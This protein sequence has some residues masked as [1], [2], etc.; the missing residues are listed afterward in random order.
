MSVRIRQAWASPNGHVAIVGDVRLEARRFGP[1]FGQSVESRLLLRGCGDHFFAFRREADSLSSEYAYGSDGGRDDDRGRGEVPAETCSGPT[2]IGPRSGRD[3]RCE[4]GK[5]VD[6]ASVRYGRLVDGCTPSSRGH[7][8]ASLERP[9]ASDESLRPVTR[10]GDGWATAVVLALVG[11]FLA[12]TALPG[13]HWHDTA[14]FIAIGR[15]LSIS[16]PPGHPVSALT[17]HGMQLL[18][19]GDAAFRANVGSAVAMACALAWFHRLIRALAP[20]LPSY[21]VIA[22]AVLPALM[23]SIW[24]QGVR[25][26]VY[27]LQ[28]LLSVAAVDISRR[29]VEGRDARWLPAL[30]LVFGLAGSNHSLVGAALLPLAVVA[31]VRGWLEW[32]RQTPKIRARRGRVVGWAAVFGAIGLTCYLYLPLRA[33]AGGIVGWGVPDRPARIW[34]T[35]SAREWQRNLVSVPIGVEDS[36]VGSEDPWIN[37]TSANVARLSAYAIDQVGPAGAAALLV[38]LA[39]G[40]MPL[41][42]RRMGLV[43]GIALVL[44]PTFGTRFFYDFD[45]HNPDIGGYFAA[46]WLALLMASVLAVDARGA[47]WS[48]WMGPII[49]GVACLALPR[50]DPHDRRGSRVAERTAR[51]M[52]EEVPVRGAMV[53]SDY[54]SAFLGWYLRGVERQRPDVALLFRGQIARPWFQERLANTDPAWS[55]RLAV[56]PDGLESPTARF[57][58]GVALERLGSLEARLAP[59][60]LTLTLDASAANL[61]TLRTIY[62]RL[63]APKPPEEGRAIATQL[64]L[65]SRRS[66][67]FLHLQHG[68]HASGQAAAGGHE[69]LRGVARWHFERVLRLAPGEPT[70]LAALERL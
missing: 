40:L 42:R 39:L 48:R 4:N 10:L 7:I 25:A 45:P 62:G 65:D 67:A 6:N 8:D 28:L 36:P 57:E 51:G 16:H 44:F 33:D 3:R 19:L 21:T 49:A 17:T 58:P 26:E 37:Q 23:P 13:P 2:A 20:Q 70:T 38:L 55:A 1:H 69:R 27:A 59:T 18:P 41:V 29:L 30:A 52:L 9:I 61:S 56:L 53:Y 43:G 5:R 47:R 14:E 54:A 50:F 60:G 34:A 35:I 31:T 66:L 63:S 11:A 46:A 64:D 68:L 32:G 24:L 15:L 12:W 22:V